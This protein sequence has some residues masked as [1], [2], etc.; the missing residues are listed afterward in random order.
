MYSKKVI[1]HFRN[2]QNMGVIRNP[3][4]WAQVGNPICGDIMKVYLKISKGEGGALKEKE[5]I[6]EIKFQTLGC[7]AAIAISSVVTAMAKGMSLTKAKNIKSSQVV[8][9]LGGL[10]PN[11]IHCSLLAVQAI[12]RALNKYQKSR[13]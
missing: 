10:P 8:K 2:P 13:I 1:E 7:A 12:K 3:D 11:K 4:A 5:Y 9:E 6:K